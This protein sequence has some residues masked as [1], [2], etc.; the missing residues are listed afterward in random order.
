MSLASSFIGRFRKAVPAHRPRPA[1]EHPGMLAFGDRE[2]DHLGAADQILLRHVADLA[3]EPAVGGV[4][5]VVAHHEEVAGRH[6][7]DVGVVEVAV[8]GAVQ[9]LIGHAVRQRF[10]PALHPRAAFGAAGVLADKFAHA[11]PLDRLCR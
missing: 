2:E 9:R 5:A 7:V 3:E 11:L 10:L 4:V 1:P 6:H 8:V